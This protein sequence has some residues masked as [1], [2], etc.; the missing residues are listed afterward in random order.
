MEIERFGIGIAVLPGQFFMTEIGL[1]V[2]PCND[3]LWNLGFAVLA[4]NW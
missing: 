4:G 1:A 2:L 3:I